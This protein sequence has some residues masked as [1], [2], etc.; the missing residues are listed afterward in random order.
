MNDYIILHETEGF[1]KVVKPLKFGWGR[2][3][4]VLAAQCSGSRI[5][6]C[7]E[8]LASGLWSWVSIQVVIRGVGWMGKLVK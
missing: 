2:L 6:V 3:S 8:L 7:L 5:G 1:W 4:A